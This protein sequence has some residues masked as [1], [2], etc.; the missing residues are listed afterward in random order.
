MAKKAIANPGTFRGPLD[1]PG[2]VGDHQFAGVMA[3]HAQ[4]RAHGRERIIAHL[5]LGVGHRIDEG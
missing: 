1:Q 2:D 4:L 5:C 3:C